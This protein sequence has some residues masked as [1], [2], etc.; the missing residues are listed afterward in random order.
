M[1]QKV[2][3][4]IEKYRMLDNC[5]NVT[6]AISG[7]ADSVC[8]IFAMLALREKYGYSLSAVH[9]N[10]NLRAEES[11]RDEEF[12]KALCHRLCVPLAVESVDVR[13]QSQNTGESTELAARNLRYDAFKKHNIGVTATA[14][15]ADDN[16]ETAVYNMSRGTGI[17]GVAGIPP[18][19]DIFIRP[20]I[21]C[22]RKDI[23]EY[24]QSLGETF[25]TDSSNMSDEYTRNFIRHNVVP[26]LQKINPAVS[27]SVGKMSENLREDEDFLSQTARKIYIICLR[28]GALDTAILRMQHPAIL[29]R[30][31]W[32]YIYENFKV[33]PDSFHLDL[34]AQLVHKGGRASISDNKTVFCDENRFY[35]EKENEISFI[36]TTKEISP[37]DLKIN[38][39]LL[40]NSI[41]CDKIKGK[42]VV[43]C[44]TEGDFIRLSGRGCT[45]TLK[46][47]MNEM[48]IPPNLRKV[49]PI[50]ADDEGV[51]WV[52]GAGVACRAAADETTKKAIIF[53]VTKSDN[54]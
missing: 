23:E 19:R 9:I 32:M 3:R 31:I 18:K 53:E 30:I 25:V 49:W 24:L 14:H 4:A 44:R 51:L 13:T 17:R 39:L 36:T 6:V 50:A 37:D 35:V 29:K 22:T 33:K 47:L 7:G 28:D 34:C 11:N 26:M 38:N 21:F 52:Y 48:K 16:L 46:K 40:K 41:D 1:L 10:H 5:D 45:K 20:L 27:R 43:R 2:I 42:L 15:T 8:L 12:V 54:L